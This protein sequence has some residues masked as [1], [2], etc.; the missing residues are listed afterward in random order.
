MFR[1]MPRTRIV[2]R[3]AKREKADQEEKVRLTQIKIDAVLEQVDELEKRAK[4][5][6]YTQI[7]LIHART[8]NHLLEMKM[9]E[10]LNLKLKYFTDYKW[11]VPEP[12]TSRARSSSISTARGRS[13]T[14]Q[15]SLLPRSLTQS[16]DG[17]NFNRGRTPQKV[18][19]M[20]FLRFPRAGELVLSS[21]GSPLAV[22]TDRREDCADVHIPTKKGV[23]MVKPLKMKQVNREV[24]MQLDAN[25]LNQVKTLKSNLEVIV[26]MATKMGKM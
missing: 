18:P 7:K 14:P 23:F 2:S 15:T 8:D 10:S 4:N 9:S 22:Q 25:V 12:P 3:Q 21:G 5:Q 19:P 6:V 1:K 13:R 20:P 26:D 16:M 24:L 11:K 17:G